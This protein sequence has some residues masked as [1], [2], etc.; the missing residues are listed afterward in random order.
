M[1]NNTVN[2]NTVPVDK[3]NIITSK[4]DSN[5]ENNNTTKETTKTISEFP[6]AS[7]SST[8]RYYPLNNNESFTSSTMLPK[9]DRDSN[10]LARI[11]NWPS[12]KL[13]HKKFSEQINDITTNENIEKN[14]ESIENMVNDGE[15]IFDTILNQSSGENQQSTSR[16]PSIFFMPQH[17]HHRYSTTR[18]VIMAATIEKLI[19]K[20]TSEIDYT[21]LTDF[22]LTYRNFISPIQL[23]NLLILRFDW[24]FE[25]EEEDRRI[26]RVRIFVAI[27]HWLLNYFSYDFVPCRELRST[28]TNH[29]NNLHSRQSIKDSPRDRRIV[30]GLKRVVKRLKRI[31]FRKDIDDMVIVMPQNKELESIG[32]YYDIEEIMIDRVENK[33]RKD[34]KSM[35]SL[36]LIDPLKQ[37][38][39]KRNLEKRRFKLRSSSM[40]VFSSK[41][42][43]SPSFFKNIISKGSNPIKKL[44][45]IY[46]EKVDNN[47]NGGGGGINR[48]K[49]SLS[50]SETICD[51]EY[52]LFRS[53]IITK[54]RNSSTPKNILNIVNGTMGRLA[55]GLFSSEKTRSPIPIS[56]IGYGFYG[57]KVSNPSWNENDLYH[58]DGFSYID[59]SIEDEEHYD[60]A[61]PEDF[62]QTEKQFENWDNENTI[63]YNENKETSDNRQLIK[64][65]RRG[66]KVW[67]LVHDL[68]SVI[69]LKD[70]E[71]K[72]C[73]RISS[74]TFSLQGLD[75]N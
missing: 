63:D 21:F 35:R 37:S 17:Q 14:I 66:A 32:H 52:D 33:K 31:Y 60:I 23:C 64:S 25:N 46:H 70:L 44:K 57:E 74:D 20:L 55:K 12:I 39:K 5:N 28:L 45:N 48:K 34:F 67:D 73:K 16:T 69:T 68:H 43:P 9:L 11:L 75:E 49:R 61:N 22:F 53:E 47:N 29:L 42:P 27:R 1:D 7:S 36:I 8:S 38:E 3:E 54:R 15:I 51:D 2:I 65:L 19:E 10:V 56:M 18:R 40:D 4:D 62:E 71:N 6:P 24:A 58:L 72:S 41:P 59:E 13:D 30:Q 26:A 50:L